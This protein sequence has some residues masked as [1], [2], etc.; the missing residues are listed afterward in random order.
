MKKIL[1][2]LL[3][4]GILFSAATVYAAKDIDVYVDG[5]KIAFDQAPFIK[6]GRT[7]VPLRAIFEALG[8]RVEYQADYKM[9]HAKRGTQYT[10]SLTIGEAELYKNGKI[11]TMDVPAMIV[12]GRTFVPL[13]AVSEALDTKVAWDGEA[14][15]VTVDSTVGYGIKT[16]YL[17]KSYLAP[18]GTVLIQYFYGYPV[19]PNPANSAYITKLNDSFFQRAVLHQKAMEEDILSH[20]EEQYAQSV[21]DG[22]IWYAYTC[23]HSF[24]ITYDK[25]LVLCIKETDYSFY[26]GAHPNTNTDAY[27]YNLKNGALLSLS[28]VF[29]VAEEEVQK[30][31]IAEFS[32]WCDMY[33]LEADV[34]NAI[35]ENIDQVSFYLTDEGVAVYFDV[36]AV[37]PYALGEPEITIPYKFNEKLYRSWVTDDDP[38]RQIP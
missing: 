2:L 7:L 37:G 26:D 25:K 17:E 33:A 38:N 20:A 6:D 31:L 4:L 9:V 34:K 35:E 10:L 27:V 5:G 15:K 22:W 21:A 19:L 18:D 3:L 32:E 1:G 36:Y 30:L 11:I 29:S 14:R 8:C 16:K 13:R 12:S 23:E 28:D 24:D